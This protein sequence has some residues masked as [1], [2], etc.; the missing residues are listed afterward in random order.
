MTRQD[1][2]R[3]P[4]YWGQA[5]IVFP[6]ADA[7]MVE[8]LVLEPIEDAL[9]E[10]EQ[11]ATVSSTAYA[12]TAVVAI[13]LED[14]DRVELVAR[15]VDGLRAEPR[16]GCGGRGAGHERVTEPGDRLVAFE[17]ED[18]Q[19]DRGGEA[20]DARCAQKSS[21]FCFSSP[22]S[23]SHDFYTPAHLASVFEV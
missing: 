16:V 12:E 7:E 8:R 20:H 19:R 4:H 1:D 9:A 22:R 6:G 11:I 21:L 23:I 17:G 3:M 5:V 10:V 2:P 13:D 14:V 18:A 15:P